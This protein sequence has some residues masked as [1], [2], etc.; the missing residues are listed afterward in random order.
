M[1]KGNCW[2]ARLHFFYNKLLFQTVESKC[3]P[4]INTP[5]PKPKEEEPPPVPSAGAAEGKEGEQKTE[6]E[7]MN[8]DEGTPVDSAKAGSASKEGEKEDMDLD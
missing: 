6:G 3:N 7:A 5:K 4:I 2:A 8:P 1:K